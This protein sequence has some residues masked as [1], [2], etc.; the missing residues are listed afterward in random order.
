PRRAIRTLAKQTAAVLRDPHTRHRVVRH[1]R[2][3]DRNYH[4]ATRTGMWWRGMPSGSATAVRSLAPQP[5]AGG[6]PATVR[7]GAAPVGYRY[8]Y[9]YGPPVRYRYG[10]PVSGTAPVQYGTPRRY[11][12]PV[13]GQAPVRRAVPGSYGA[14]VRR[15]QGRPVPGRGYPRQR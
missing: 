12:T 6:A 5:A 13:R 3:L 1:A 4:H 7:Y 10:V 9:G 2:A 8:R 11:G 14:P 15:V